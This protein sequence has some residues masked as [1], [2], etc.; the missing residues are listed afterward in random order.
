MDRGIVPEGSLCTL[1]FVN[2]RGKPEHT[3]T[4]TLMVV[5]EGRLGRRSVLSLV[6]HNISKQGIL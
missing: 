5:M 4:G 1:P 3:H 6:I 2:S